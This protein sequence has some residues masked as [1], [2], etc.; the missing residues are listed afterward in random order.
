MSKERMSGIPASAVCYFMDGDQWCAVHGDFVNL[1]ESPA[2]FGTTMEEA[3]TALV[4]E[5]QKLCD[6]ARRCPICGN[7]DLKYPDG[8]CQHGFLY[9]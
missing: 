2:G 3:V 9:H 5:D 4:A 1:A 6:E 7:D 8:E